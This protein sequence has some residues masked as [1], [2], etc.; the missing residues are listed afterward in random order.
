MF[1][2][3]FV[4]LADQAGPLAPQ[5]VAGIIAGVDDG[6]ELLQSKLFLARC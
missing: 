1:G 4:Q 3:G 6:L 2:D 5:L